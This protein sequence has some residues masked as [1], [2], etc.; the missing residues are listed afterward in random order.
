MVAT[1]DPVQIPYPLSTA[2]GAN[3]QEGS[4]RL[5][6]C[7]AEPLGDPQKPTGPA[8][9]VWRRSPGLS[10]HALTAQ[11]GYRGGL[12]V[13]NLSYETWANEAAT[14]D[15]NGVVTLLGNLPGTKNVSIARN[16][17]ATPDVV[18]VDL[19]NGAYILNTAALA[20]AT[21]TITVGG[22]AFEPGDSITLQ[23]VNVG[24]TGFPVT[25]THTLGSGET[26]TTIATALAALIN[27]NATLS[28]ALL[29]AVSALGVVTVSQSGAI[30][31]ATT[32]TVSV[33]TVGNSTAIVGAKTG[34]GNETV[35]IA[36][37]SGSS[38]ATI[39]GSVFT[40]GDSVSLTFSNPGLPSFP[41]TVVYTLGAGSSATIIAT[42]LTALINANATLLAAGITAASALGVVTITQAIGNET[43]VF[44]PASGAMAG[45]AGT[46]GIVFTGAP[47]AYN[48]GGNLPQP[49]SVCFQDGYLFFTV[50]NGRVYATA[51][52]SL[53]MNALTYITVQARQDVTLLRGVAYNGYL[54]L[55][56]TGSCELWQDNALPAPQFP[57]GRVLVND[58]GLIQPT[59]IAGWET[60]FAQLMWVA[61]D[62]GVY[63]MPPN[64]MAP[65]K[66]SSP[67][68]EKLIEAQVRLGNTLEAGCYAFA[69]KKFWVLSSP[70]WSWEFNL[71]TNRWNER[72]SLNGGVYGRF[73]ARLGH[74]AFGKW[75]VGDQQSGKL[76]WIDSGNYTE[77]G[78]P[79]LFRIE[80]GP[81][82]LFPSQIRIARMDADFDAGV[83]IAVSNFQMIVTGAAAGTGGV[84]RLTVNDTSQAKT[85]DQVNVS[86]IV[87]T[88]EANSSWPITV[89]DGTHIELQG[90][91]FK[92]A[93]VSGGLAIDVT[94]A[95]NAVLPVAAV[96]CSKDGALTWDRPSIRHLGVQSKSKRVRVSIKTRGLSGPMGD[97]WRIDVTDP[98]YVGF[99]GATQSSNPREV[100]A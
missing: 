69:G 100:G 21:A 12:I 43:V 50:A 30:G 2:P 45:G 72:W 4:G 94:A 49:N 28:Q 74:P 98:V 80:S 77:D 31:N 5:I 64:T 27:A 90:S 46:Q 32:I 20:S 9:Q 39:A 55:F 37:G 24:I 8:A 36:P 84:V 82:R 81:V 17:A 29:T 62:F 56:T 26:A 15:V 83:G 3:P 95:P 53:A 93:Y 18:A 78:S 23:F 58:Y 10:Q 59:A 6:N 96:S 51:I 7:Y 76:L 47:L 99:M 63:L 40:S 33:V 92:N 44:N 42:G 68:L 38:T 86:A 88:V 65:G 85:N 16:L 52:N 75:L 71:T 67:D 14:V 79:Q 11:A 25:L 48:G 19:D 1:T 89:I 34:T 61:Q 22:S 70:A 35:T 13:N 91:V 97:R 66:V 73:R 54:L 57:Y 87:G 41:I 60:G